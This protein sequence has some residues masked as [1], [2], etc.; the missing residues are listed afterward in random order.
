MDSCVLISTLCS[1]GAAAGTK[2]RM[3]EQDDYCLDL[4]AQLPTSLTDEQRKLF[5]QLAEA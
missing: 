3:K 4:R 2:G 1:M 5:E